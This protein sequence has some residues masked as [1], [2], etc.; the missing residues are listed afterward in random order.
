MFGGNILHSFNIPMQLSIHEIENRTKV[1]VGVRPCAADSSTPPLESS[2]LR[3]RG[4]GTGPL[5]ENMVRL[6]RVNM[7]R[8]RNMLVCD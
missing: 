5:K 8:I 6:R 2:S 7:V 4:R 1:G 3:I